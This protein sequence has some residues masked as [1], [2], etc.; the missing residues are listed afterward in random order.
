M[1]IIFT[2]VDQPKNTI[3]C[4]YYLS[5]VTHWVTL[6]QSLGGKLE[7]YSK[8][9]VTPYI[10]AMVYHVPR[11]M[12]K[13]RGVKKFTGQGKSGSLSLALQTKIIFLNLDIK[14]L[15]YR[16]REAE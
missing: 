4:T 13:H 10:H 8:A 7:G 9:N 12:K 6:F 14:M 11:F 1:Y 5:Q 16:C 2:I 15:M 3:S